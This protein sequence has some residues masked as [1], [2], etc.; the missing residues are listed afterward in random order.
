MSNAGIS[1]ILALFMNMATFKDTVWYLQLFGIFRFLFFHYIISFK[2][3]RTE[4]RPFPVRFIA[5]FPE[6]R[7]FPPNYAIIIRRS[8]A[9]Q[10]LMIPLG[11]QW[12]RVIIPLIRTGD[13]NSKG[14]QLSA[15]C[16]SR[17]VPLKRLHAA[18]TPR[19]S[20]WSLDL[21]SSFVGPGRC[22]GYPVRSERL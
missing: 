9:C 19:H 21:L 10:A 14:F 7:L 18:W 20:S 5:V 15:I 3:A 2:S 16:F 1:T 22:P 8:R 11:E 13:V 12:R 4:L 17:R 6:N